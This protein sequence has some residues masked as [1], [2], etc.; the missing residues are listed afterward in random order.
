[1]CLLV[2]VLLFIFPGYGQADDDFSFTLD[3]IEKKPLQ[4]GGYT[5]LKFEHLDSNQDGVLSILNAP[6]EQPA[7]IDR[8][9]PG[10]QIDGSYGKGMGSFNWLLK[11]GGR[12][13]NYGWTD[14]AD[15]Y[16]AYGRIKANKNSTVD[17]GKKAYKW[18]KGYAW[19]PVG[20]I[21]RPKDPNDPQEALEG[22]ITAELDLIKSFTG[23]HS[24]DN[25]ALTTVLLPVYDTINDE[26]GTEN[27]VNFA[28]KLYLLYRD[29]DIDLLLYTGNSRST[30]F[31]ADFS[32]NI[33]TNFEIHGEAAYVLDEKK[34]LLEE[35]GSSNF[36][37]GNRFNTLLGLRYLSESDLTT[38]M[39]YYYNGNGYTKEQRELFYHYVDNGTVDPSDAEK[40]TFLQ[41][42]RELS[43]RGY[44][45]PSVGRNYLYAK[46]TQK[47]PFDILYFTPALTTIINLDDGSTSLT[48]EIAYTGITN[49][50][51]R[52]RFSL[53]IGGSFSE[54]GEKL[55]SNKV[56]LRLRYFF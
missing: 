34:I 43:M 10:I 13:D 19:N 29:T 32:K 21:N 47:E 4:W 44:G 15:I 11:A 56:E 51:L 45:K 41:R 38:I 55:S 30:R 35:D 37:R 39:E 12:Q 3:E 48:P 23:M 1:F 27:N 14:Y 52:L 6:N 8:F 26:F 9:S 49:L 7:T 33:R 5:E 28:A 54:F 20:F 40:N 50:E 16:E 25:M 2:A 18:G 42:A 22:Y 36:E 53:L 24:L 17:L 31:G 46:F